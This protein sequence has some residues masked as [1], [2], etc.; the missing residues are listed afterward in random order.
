MK[1]T[2][3]F[4]L[5]VGWLLVPQELSAQ[6]PQTFNYQGIARDA[7]GNVLP[8]RTIG[9]ELSVL[10]G[11][12]TGTVVYQETFTDTTNAFGLFTMHVGGGSVVSG[13]FA[14]INWATGN[15]YLQTAID[16]T[17]GTN[18]TL[19]GTTQLLSVPYALYAQN[20]VVGV[21]SGSWSLK[22]NAGTGDTAFI[23][24]TDNTPLLF[25]VNDS[26]SGSIRPNSNETYFGYLSGKKAV[27]D[28]LN[29]TVGNTAF[30]AQTLT[31]ATSAAYNTAVG[32]EALLNSNGDANTAIGAEALQ[33][34][35]TGIYNTG[36]GGS[37]GYTNVTGDYLTLVG[38]G[39]DVSVDGLS[40][41]TA[42]G[43]NAVV[44]ANNMVQI[45]SSGVTVIQGQVPFTTPS[46]GRFKF[47][48]RED[49]KGVDFIL[50]LRPVTYQ[51]NTKKEE[52][53]IRGVKD[54]AGA[55]PVVFNEAMMVRR[56][57]F[58]AQEVEKAAS[59]SGYDFDGLRAPKTDREYYSLSY[60]SFVVPLVKAVQ[61]QEGV[62]ARQEQRI[63]ELTKEMEE[64]RQ[65]VLAATKK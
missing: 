45:G 48:V 54:S 57:G 24:T 29:E 30:G 46:D 35:E 53:F 39:A 34:T 60:A 41:A 59:Q 27:G 11:G 17:G 62:I 47:N 64:L 6:V 58:I 33:N 4:L 63:D 16:L 52:D 55:M 14:G 43:A 15:K 42:L 49:V 5:A 28:V 1:K 19:S 18:Y 21:S 23:G 8:N 9:L 56:T 40:N 12:P 31:Y 36:L 26:A 65:L 13:S 32:F 10:D 44:T 37:A 38:V 3:L 61:E 50:K 7:G 51:F 20:A 2:L 25:K 22:G